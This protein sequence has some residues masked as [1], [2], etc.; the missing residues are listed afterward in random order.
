M[1]VKYYS[2]ETDKVKHIYFKKDN[3]LQP[4]GEFHDS[5]EMIFMLNGEIEAYLNSQTYNLKAGDIFFV[6]SYDGHWYKCV[7]ESVLA[8]VLVLSRDYLQSFFELYPGQTFATVLNDNTK[9]KGI[10]ELVERWYNEQN[11]TYI[12]NVGYVNV[13]FSY[14]IDRYMLVKRLPKNERNQFVVQLLSYIHEHYLENIT[15]N[16]TARTLGYS[17]DH[18]A[19][20]MKKYI[21]KDFREYV[22]MLR[23][24]KANELMADTSV[25]LTT[26]EILYKCGFQSATTYYR[27]KKRFEND[28]K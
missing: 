7:T 12:K 3:L 1:K 20:T 8:Y 17:K 23:I 25:K 27:A 26:L 24:K 19:R 5:I 16:S 18:C 4:H 13:L 6:D 9:N 14:L 2:G 28:I 11:K 21:G 22:N 10:F 15:I